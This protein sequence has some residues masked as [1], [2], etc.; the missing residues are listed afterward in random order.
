MKILKKVIKNKF[1]IKSDFWGQELKN[2]IFINCKFKQSI[3]CDVIFKN[4]VFTNCLITDCNFSHSIFYR[5]FF[6]QTHLSKNNFRDAQRDR[7]SKLVDEIAL[8]KNNHKK[9]RPLNKIEKRIFYALTKGPGFILLKNI[10]AKK[11]IKKAFNIIDYKVINDPVIKANKNFFSRD[12]KFNQKWIY[13]LLNFDKIFVDFIHPPEP[14]SNVFKK[15]LGQRYICGFYG[16]NCLLPG[17]RG[18]TA[19]LDYPYYRFVKPNEKVPF[20]SRKFFYLNCQILTP[21]TVFNKQNGSTVFFPHSHKLNKYPNVNSH[22]NKKNKFLQL[23]INPGSI[24]IFNGLV[25]HYAAPNRSRNQKRYGLLAQYIP[26]YITP[27]LD[28]RTVTK[29][30]ILESNQSLRNLLGVNLEFPSVRF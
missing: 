19:H 20:Q 29:K 13:R 1:F 18:Q 23:K 6:K 17:A 16:A 8:I 7:Y 26:E 12:K 15:L 2:L 27:M 3:F 14:V 11:K 25:W 30:R 4:V 24:L 9:E 28:L 22:K 5:T 10:F 21:L